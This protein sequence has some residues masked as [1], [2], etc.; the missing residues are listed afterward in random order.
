MK[1]VLLVDDDPAINFLNKIILQ[2]TG[3]FSDIK[4]VQNGK[5]ALDLIASELKSQRELPDIIFLDLNM[6][7][8]GGFAF[9]KSFG[10]LDFVGKEDIRI[11]IL[12]S[13]D[14]EEDKKIALTFGVREYYTKPISLDAVINI[15]SQNSISKA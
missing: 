8:M 12:S 15:L 10:K 6:P 9:L 5:Q 7:V 14:T 1:K 3:E 2:R 11:V 13:S 4:I